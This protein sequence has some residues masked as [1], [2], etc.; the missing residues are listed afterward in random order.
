MKTILFLNLNNSGSS[1]LLLGQNEVQEVA[2]VSN[3]YTAQYGR[4]AGVQV[5]YSTKSGSNAFH[6]NAA[7]FYNSSGFNANDW[8]QKQ[9]KSRPAHHPISSLLL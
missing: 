9:P 1:N 4:Q 2:V 5:D 8:F 7:F 6:G 3:G